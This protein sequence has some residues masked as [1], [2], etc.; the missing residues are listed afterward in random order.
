MLFTLFNLL[1]GPIIIL[2]EIFTEV[3]VVSVCCLDCKV[4]TIDWPVLDELAQP[5]YCN[6][7]SDYDQI[8]R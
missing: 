3:E 8:H 7:H 1:L 2:V 4:L 5:I 6:V